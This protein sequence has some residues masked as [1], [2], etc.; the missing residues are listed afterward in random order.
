MNITCNI[1]FVA[2]SKQLRWR[3]C[4]E[5]NEIQSYYGF[6]LETNHWTLVHCIQLIDDDE[7]QPNILWDCP[8]RLL[9]LFLPVA[10]YVFYGNQGHSANV[11]SL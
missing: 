5:P 4:K 1:G 8:Q 3:I 2:S 9:H 10:K 7:T 6:G 11:N